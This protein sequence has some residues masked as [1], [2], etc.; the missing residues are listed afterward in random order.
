PPPDSYYAAHQKIYPREI[1]GRY[2]RLRT[3]AAWVLLGL[4]YLVPWMS[5]QGRQAVLFDLPARKFYVFGLVLW[6]QDFIFLTGLLIIAALS[7]FFFTALA[8][9][10]WC[11]YACP[12]TVWTEVYLWMERVAEGT[13]SERMKLDAA[14]WSLRKL[15]RKS[16]K[17]VLWISFGLWTGLTFVGYFTPMQ[18]LL[19]GVATL[20]IGPWETFWALFYGFATYGNRSAE[21]RVGRECTC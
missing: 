10:L 17:Q 5:W 14:P 20:S 18:E 9:R 7:L 4:F 3:L 16:L 19:H 2:A 8:G 12:Q 6:P 1:T 21:R 11:G 13:R 15:A